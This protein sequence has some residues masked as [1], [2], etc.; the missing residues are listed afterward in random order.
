MTSHRIVIAGASSLLGGELKLLLEESR[1][2]ASDF[3]L[4]DEEIAVG[5]LTEAGGEPAV[6][7]PVEE[8]SFNRA[9]FI[10][11]TGSAA[12]TKA[13]LDLARRSGAVI[14]DLSGATAA[15]PGAAL[16]FSNLDVLRPSASLSS[17]KIFAI[18]SAAAMAGATLSF[19]LAKFQPEYF[20]MTALHPISECG[21]KGIEELE[22]QTTQLLSFQS[23]GSPVFDTQV[24]F[25]LL[26]RFGSGSSEKLS[27]AR[28][29]LRREISAILGVS[30]KIP[31][32]QLIQAPVFYGTAFTFA[33]KL[34][35]SA[36]AEQLTGAAKSA[37]LSI[38]ADAAPSNVSVAGGSLIQLAVP[39]PDSGVSGLWWFWGA[40][41]NMRVPA[42]NA[43]KLA[44]KLLA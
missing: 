16:W 44:E 13:N 15:E 4:L 27:S 14:V 42:V 23:V 19:V 3:H 35:A 17:H 30:A 8:D 25:N 34:G 21:R 40:A 37:G 20:T 9:N 31:A 5:T 28:E 7:R 29:R 6:I 1:F 36:S 24:G 2:A 38:P 22:Q 39:E 18:P 33:A 43:L 10:F 26:D 11:F 41:D 32:V 12:F